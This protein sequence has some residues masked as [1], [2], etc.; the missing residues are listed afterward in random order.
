MIKPLF[1]IK[2]F[3]QNTFT[4][5]IGTLMGS[6]YPK[7]KIYELQLYKGVLCH[8]NEEWYKTWRGIDL[9]VQNWHEEFDNFWSEHSKILKVCTLISC[10]WPK[11]IMLKLKQV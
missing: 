2:L 7:Y 6:F 1:I 5:K 4:L 8:D 9:S 11:H 10:F 3:A